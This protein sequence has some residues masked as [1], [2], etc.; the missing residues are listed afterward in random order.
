MRVLVLSPEKR[1]EITEAVKRAEAHAL[2]L[3]L[4]KTGITAPTFDLK[5][6]DRK[7]GFAR[8]ASEAVEI[9]FGYRA[10][11]SI[12]EQPIGLCDHLSV[13]VDDPARLPSPEAVKLIA[14]AF[15]MPFNELVTLWLEE[16]EPGHRA[17]NVITRREAA[18]P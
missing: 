3:S 8:P 15:G 4:V 6:A 10:A 17:V 9:P 18:R 13:S 1:A 5:L 16:F 11:F 7:P 2:P 12:E 14:E